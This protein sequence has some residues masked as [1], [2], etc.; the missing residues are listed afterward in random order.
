VHWNQNPIVTH[1]LS[2]PFTGM[3]SALLLIFPSNTMRADANHFQYNLAISSSASGESPL[4]AAS[5]ALA[6]PLSLSFPSSLPYLSAAGSFH[7][8]ES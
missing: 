5:T 6:T 2:L 7:S 8:S 4:G 1:P 3:N